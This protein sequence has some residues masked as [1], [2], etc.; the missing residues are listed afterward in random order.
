M[1]LIIKIIIISIIFL[2]YKKYDNKK[3]NN[4][5]KLSLN[6]FNSLSNLKLRIDKIFDNYQI[7]YKSNIYNIKCCNVN[8]KNTLNGTIYCIFDNY[9]CSIYCRNIF[10]INKK[11]N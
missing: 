5:S 2:I 4:L 7:F 6:S 9:F 8:C 11:L 10:I 3:I 1:K